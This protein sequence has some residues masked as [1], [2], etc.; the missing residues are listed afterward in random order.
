M[1]PPPSVDGPNHGLSVGFFSANTPSDL[2]G[3]RVPCY[4]IR[5]LAGANG[6]LVP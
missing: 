1:S 3:G 5:G 6:L 2:A 4:L